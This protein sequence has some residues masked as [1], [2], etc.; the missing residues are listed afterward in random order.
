M[1]FL[2]FFDFSKNLSKLFSS[3]VES[4]EKRTLVTALSFNYLPALLLIAFSLL[5]G[6]RCIFFS[7]TFIVRFLLTFPV[8]VYLSAAKA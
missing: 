8:S 7:A 1:S 3:T 4:V 2:R 6:L 5:L